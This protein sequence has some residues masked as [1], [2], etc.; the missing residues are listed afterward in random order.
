MS[1]S[2]AVTRFNEETWREQNIYMNKHSSL[3]YNSPCQITDKIPID[4]YVIVLE[5]HNDDNHIKGIGLIKNYVTHKKRKIFSDPNYNRFTYKSLY[6]IDRH[7]L[8]DF[9]ETILK[10]F[11]IVCFTGKKHLKRGKGIQRIPNEIIVK[12]KNII[13]FPSYFEKLFKNKI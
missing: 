12:C 3:I 8:T 7:D 5:M 13:Y 1:Y 10:F 6:R 9:D 11:D 2:I 4:N